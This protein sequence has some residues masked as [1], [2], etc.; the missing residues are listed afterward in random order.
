M[1]AI[2]HIPAFRFGRTYPSLD[3]TTLSDFRGQHPIA[4]ISQVNAGLIRRDLNR[5]RPPPESMTMAQRCA[6]GAEAARWFLHE[7]LPAGEG[8]Q[9]GPEEYVRALSHTGGLPHALVRANLA[10]IHRVLSDLP[11]ILTG[12]TRGLDASLI[13]RGIGLHDGRLMSFYPVARALGVVLPSNSPGV[14]SLWLPAVALGIPV[15][16]KPGREDPWT[17]W[18][19]LQAL[20]AA[21]CPPELLG[22]YPTDHEG[23]D[24]VVQGCDRA[25][26]FGDAATVERHAGNPAVNVHGPG[27]SKVLIAEDRIAEWPALLDLLADSVALNSGRSCVNASTIVVPRH[28]AEIAAALAERLA[29]HQPRALDDPEA[30]LAGFANPSVAQ[31]TD[32]QVEAGFAAGGAEDA[33]APFR[34]QPRL[35]QRDGVTYL[36]PTVAWCRDPQHRLARTEFLFPFAAVVEIPQADML[37]WIGPTLV[38][39]VITS[40]PAFA[41]AT[42]RCP[43]IDRLNLGAVATPTVAWDQPHEGN[44]FEFLYRRRA[45]QL[46]EP[47]G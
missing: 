18:R 28:G 4:E 25:I 16:L 33:S 7:T 13:D 3:R 44:L 35:V 32:R 39:T 15:V 31:W 46:E 11:A 29:A 24:A 37:D 34:D 30:T 5:L 36:L 2:P 1:S 22:F 38:A 9:H 45:V 21:G 40:N 6:C 20:L 42:V 43:H 47:G 41:Q 23:A 14:N 8:V 26:L 10:K 27:F 12:L 17:P 19:I